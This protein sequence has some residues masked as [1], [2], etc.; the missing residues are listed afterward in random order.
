MQLQR[1]CCSTLR[2]LTLFSLGLRSVN[3]T[4]EVNWRRMFK[5]LA[6]FMSSAI[7]A[8]VVVPIGILS[9]VGHF[10]HRPV[11][12]TFLAFLFVCVP[13]F[14]SLVA[15]VL[16]QWLRL[17]TITV[18]EEAIQ[19]RTYWMRKKKIPLRDIT[20]LTPFYGKAIRGIVVHSQH[21]GRIYISDQT[22]RL[23]ELLGILASYARQHER[24]NHALRPTTGRSAV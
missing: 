8:G 23:S 22:E 3:A 7:I 16:S 20:K 6:I 15:F 5:S 4:F 17:S 12:F 11:P 18:S 10:R 9:V 14:C 19:G 1:S 13:L 2:W 21:H 24:P